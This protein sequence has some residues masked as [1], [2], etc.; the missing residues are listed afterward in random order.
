MLM[1]EGWVGKKREES[2]SSSSSRRVNAHWKET[3]P[4]EVPVG[5][6]PAN[7]ASQEI[8]DKRILPEEKAEWSI[9]G[10]GGDSCSGWA[11]R[12]SSKQIKK[13][14]ERKKAGRKLYNV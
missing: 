2:S 10:E 14:R 9:G 3:E 4:L 13:K 12:L 8:P 7:R 11:G 5:C 1:K 6:K